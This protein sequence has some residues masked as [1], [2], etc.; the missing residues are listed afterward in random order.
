MAE[1]DAQSEVSRRFP[2]ADTFEGGLATRSLSDLYAKKAVGAE[3]SDDDVLPPQSQKTQ[4]S[5]QSPE[6]LDF[7]PV[8]RLGI[9]DAPHPAQFG[10]GP[11]QG[12]DNP[13]DVFKDPM[14]VLAGLSSLFTRR[15]LTAAMNYAAGAMEGYHKGK[16][17][18][19][20][21]NKEKFDEAIRATIEQN[22]VELARYN[23]AWDRKKEFDWQK[24]AP[25]LYGE[26][27]ANNDEILAAAIR[28]GRW[29]MVEK[30]LIGKE[31]AQ[32]HIIQAEALTKIRAEYGSGASVDDIQNTIHGIERGLLP[33]SLIGLYRNRAKVEG[34]L[35]K[36]KFNL[37]QA[38]LEWTRAQT[39]IKSLNGPQ[40]LRFVGLAGSVVNTI[41][42]VRRL[43]DEMQLSGVPLLNKLQL[44]TYI[45]AEG[46]T[47]NGQLAAKY[48]GAVNTLKEEFANLAQGGYAPTESVWALAN[49]QIDENYGVKELGASLDEIQRL[50]RYRVNAVPGL[51][52]FGPG[53]PNSYM[54]QTNQAPSPDG[55]GFEE[56]K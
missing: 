40:M 47:P 51:S 46:N 7:S 53:A 37:A 6:K 23:E 54:P 18:I 38:Q 33:P 49:R 24:V 44:Q 56:I 28:S 45:K 22:K 35:A 1:D 41:D 55:W 43:S 21:D 31:T 5:P 17:D 25:K 27:I 32:E 2:F 11:Q 3:T 39:Q 10:L 20:K 9:H 12:Q 8:P 52:Q 14:V 19:F 48:L 50:I 42:E 29:D 13:F 26:A 4:L 36:D 15:P 16:Q 30:I 34:G